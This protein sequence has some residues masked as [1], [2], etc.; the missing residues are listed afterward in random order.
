MA[1]NLEQKLEQILEE[2]NIKIKPENL[3]EGVTA[4]GIPGT[5][6]P[7]SITED[8]TATDEDIFS[9]KVAYGRNEKIM[10][11]MPNNGTLDYSPS[12]EQQI[13]PKGYTDG[14][15]IEAIP[16][17]ELKIEV[18]EQSQS[19]EGIYTKVDVD[20]IITEDLD[21]MPTRLPQT[22]SGLYKNINIAGENN[23]LP[24]N[25]AKDKTIFGIT[26]THEGGDNTYNVTLKN[27]AS[28]T[29]F[30]YSKWATEV[31]TL[32]FTNVT[33]ASSAF[34][35]WSNL[36]RIGEIKNTNKVTNMNM[37]FNGCSSLPTI[38]TLD[39]SKVNS[40][41]NMFQNCKALKTISNFSAPVATKI[42][43]LFQNCTG[44]TTASSLDFRSASDVYNMFYGCT[45]LT[46]VTDLDIHTS[47]SA[48]G[49]FYGCTKIKTIG[50]LDMSYAVNIQNMFNNC[51][52]LVNFG[53]LKNLGK[54]YK[55]NGSSSVY[56][57]TLSSCSKLSHDSLMNVINGLYD[58]NLT[59]DV[60][61]GGT[62]Y[63]YSLVLG[64]TNI[65][66]LSS[67]ELSIA[68]SK[69]WKVS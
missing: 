22:Y 65:A 5:L 3:R 8:A 56:T 45:A 38:P 14:G 7:L 37:M 15:I 39:Y 1:T 48:N 64:S 11:T 67:E 42:Y 9:G 47:S 50:E 20:P 33:D 25:I 32:D 6:K 28:L 52:A 62:L 30:S 16:Q 55:S 17:N 41:Y 69:G 63:S 68:T 35:G 23:L 46:E 40:M 44:L 18:K 36:T 29:S 59:F 54:S 66:K 24:E 34:S 31:D 57:L 49:M 43:G 10:G 19:F 4:F 61:N 27:N 21:I 13:I 12:L 2:K 53:G 26:G 51:T 60:A 58:L